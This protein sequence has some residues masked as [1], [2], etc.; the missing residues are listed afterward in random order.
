MAAPRVT[1]VI[2]AGGKGERLWPLVRR[3]TPKV[4]LA[5]DGTRTLLQATLDRLAAAWPGAEWLIVT[6]K[7]QAAPVRAGVPP[8]LRRRVIVEPQIKN[9][10]AC[11][12]LAVALAR[13]RGTHH[14]IVA[15][16]ADHWVGNLAAFRTA[17]R[18][19]IRAAAKTGA[20][21]TIGLRPTHAHPG[22]GYIV[23]GR[24]AGPGTFRVARFVEKPGAAGA[25][26]LLRT[27]RVWWNSG[28]FIGTTEAF[29]REFRRQLPRHAGHLL[30]L[31][32]A[33]RQWR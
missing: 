29:V 5:P 28:M 23:G 6:T 25:T 12:A 21:V 19:A 14:V 24:Q 9:T 16:P 1:F 27:R 7:D 18:Q 15:V 20:L 26:R 4:C 32:Q 8:R 31:G 10:A 33:V 2:M 22:L 17:V 13:A 3:R 11:L 30:P